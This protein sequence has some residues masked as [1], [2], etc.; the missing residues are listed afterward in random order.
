MSPITV[1]PFNCSP[2]PEGNDARFF[3]F[4]AQAS[5]SKTHFIF[6]AERDGDSEKMHF[7]RDYIN[8]SAD[9]N[10]LIVT[11]RDKRHEIR[12]EIPN[13]QLD[14]L[15]SMDIISAISIG[16]CRNLFAPAA[17]LRAVIRGA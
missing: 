11:R 12:A 13:T 9:S 16:N 8:R 14:T 6:L 5:K 10:V 2:R 3:S 7:I 17:Y 4:E 1:G 15:E